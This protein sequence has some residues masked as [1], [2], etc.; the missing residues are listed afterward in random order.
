MRAVCAVL[1]MSALGLSACAGGSSTEGS[2]GVGGGGG[3]SPAS[4][5]AGTGSSS[6]TTSGGNGGGSPGGAVTCP[7]PHGWSY[8]DGPSLCQY[9]D[10]WMQYYQN[11]ECVLN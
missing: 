3:G 8:N 6:S 7:D 4:S 11:A 1:I 5:G 10:H 9:I 2:A